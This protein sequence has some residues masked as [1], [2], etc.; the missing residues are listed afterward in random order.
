[1]FMSTNRCH[2]WHPAPFTPARYRHVGYGGAWFGKEIRTTA[3]RGTFSLSWGIDTAANIE[4]KARCIRSTFIRAAPVTFAARYYAT[5]TALTKVLRRREAEAISA[6]GL[7]LVSVFEDDPTYG[8]YFT[9]QRGEADARAASGYALGAIDQPA[10]SPIYFAVDFDAQPSERAAI[11]A[12][13]EGVAAA[14]DKAGRHYAVGVYG[15]TWVLSWIAETHLASYFWQSQSPGWS[16]GT[17]RTV[18]RDANMKQRPPMR[19]CGIV[20]D[21]DESWGRGGGWRY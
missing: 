5:D 4:S 20:A 14:I 7:W 12:Y 2:V 6:A 13:F 16:G 8:S 17:N 18:S 3:L 19:L 21:V 1:M 11:V 9:R 15:S 10:D